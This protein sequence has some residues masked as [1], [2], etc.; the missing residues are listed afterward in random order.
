MSLY[1]LTIRQPWVNC[2]IHGDKRIENRSWSPPKAVVG[3][4]LALHAGRVLD[5]APATTHFVYDVRQMP[6]WTEE[7]LVRSA[8]L[9]VAR[10]VGVVESSPDPWFS[11]LYGW[12]LD[13]VVAIEPVP[14]SGKQGVWELPTAV[15][16]TVRQHYQTAVQS[17]A[18]DAEAYIQQKRF[19]M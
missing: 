7:E 3:G 4:F 14:C 8:I 19:G 12:V 13:E 18:A 6:L 10:L 2:I 16:T 5:D 1:A 9:G 11:G 17:H 15:L